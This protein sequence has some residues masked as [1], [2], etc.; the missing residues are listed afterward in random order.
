MSRVTEPWSCSSYQYWNRQLLKYKL[1]SC[2]CHGTYWDHLDAGTC[3]NLSFCRANA[4]TCFQINVVFIHH[5]LAVTLPPR[6]SSRLHLPY[7]CLFNV[8][9]RWIVKI[10]FCL[11]WKPFILWGCGDGSPVLVLVPCRV[12]APGTLCPAYPQMFPPASS[13]IPRQEKHIPWRDR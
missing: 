3:L 4:D 13:R 10:R 6:C 12:L 7:L 11:W 9:L 1:R 2:C 8:F 5:K